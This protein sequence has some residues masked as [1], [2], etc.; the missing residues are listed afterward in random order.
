[1]LGQLPHAQLSNEGTLSWI[2]ILDDRVTSLSTHVQLDGDSSH[3][4]EDEVVIA[5]LWTRT[6]EGATPIGYLAVDLNGDG[7]DEIFIN[8]HDQDRDEA[9]WMVSILDGSTGQVLAQ[10]TSG[11]IL[12]QLSWTLNGEGEPQL[13][14]LITEDSPAHD[15]LGAKPSTIQLKRINLSELSSSLIGSSEDVILIEGRSLWDTPLM[16]TSPI[17]RSAPI[18]HTDEF[19]QLEVIDH[20]GENAVLLRYDRRERG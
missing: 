12:G 1:M 15:E 19:K 2:S 17:W 20:Q 3:C 11:A 10:M 8:H 5:P 7:F 14:L 4:A 16:N 18:D 13:D 6:L 9:T